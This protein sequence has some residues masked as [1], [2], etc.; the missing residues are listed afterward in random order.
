MQRARGSREGGKAALVS[1]MCV[2]RAWEPSMLGPGDLSPQSQKN[3]SI[4]AAPAPV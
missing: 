4:C 2:V 1:E 3:V